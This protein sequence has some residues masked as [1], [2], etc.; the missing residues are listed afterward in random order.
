MD[1]TTVF[2]KFENS[3]QPYFDE[4]VKTFYKDTNLTAAIS[5][6]SEIMLYSPTFYAIKA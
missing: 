2:K 1:Y 3:I 4:F 5:S 6:G